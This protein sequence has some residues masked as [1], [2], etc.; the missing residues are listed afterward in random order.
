MSIIWNEILEQHNI[1]PKGAVRAQLDKYIDGGKLPNQNVTVEHAELVIKNTINS[2]ISVDG[3][4]L[5]I[6]IY[7]FPKKTQETNPF[8]YVLWMGEIGTEPP[9]NWW[10]DVV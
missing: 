2:L 8:D 6:H 1:K 4:H 5:Y 10:E 3:V 9:V 7:S